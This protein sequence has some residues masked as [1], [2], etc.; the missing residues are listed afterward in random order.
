MDDGTRLH[1]TVTGD[2]PAVVLIH[3][4]GGDA[5]AV[6]PQVTERLSSR[7]RVIAPDLSGT[8]ETSDPGG[9][10]VV[11]ALAAQVLAAADDADADRFDVAAY[12]FGTP[13][14]LALAA[15]H[16]ERVRSLALVAAWTASDARQ[17][18]VFG[19]LATAFRHDRELAARFATATAFSPAF[20][21]QSGA[22]GA[23]QVVAAFASIL[24]PGTDRQFD[25]AAAVDVDA[26]VGRVVAPALVVG[27]T[28]DL[29]VP[30]VHARRLA[31]VLPGAT[32]VEEDT[33]HALP[34]ER[35]ERFVELIDGFLAGRADALESS[36]SARTP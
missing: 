28:H 5:S 9:P 22:E 15:A 20:F 11:D 14:A 21:E 23:E 30:V 36:S 6:W 34:W 3:G 24:A 8:A 31:E 16:P 17:R 26:L 2:G 4:A 13:V 33:G 7:F 27:L 35:P 10:I 25:A 12:S 32:Y 19:A 29:Q 18:F 1:Y